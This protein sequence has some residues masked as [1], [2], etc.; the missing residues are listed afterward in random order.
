[1][2]SKKEQSVVKILLIK[3]KATE[4]LYCI[5]AILEWFG[6]MPLPINWGRL[7]FCCCL[8]EDFIQSTQA[9]QQSL[10]KRSSHQL[11]FLCITTKQNLISKYLQNLH[12]LTPFLKKWERS[13]F[14]QSLN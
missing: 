3:L 5:A 11:S 13:R 6:M 12:P 10:L 7:I 14:R 2:T 8:S 4:F 9:K 1:M